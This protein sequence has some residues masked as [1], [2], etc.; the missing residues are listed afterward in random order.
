M[1]VEN[2][3]K[4]PR[5]ACLANAKLEIVLNLNAILTED[6]HD[7]CFRG[8]MLQNLAR[9]WRYSETRVVESKDQPANSTRR[10]F[11]QIM[12]EKNLYWPRPWSYQVSGLT[13]KTCVYIN[14]IFEEI[15]KL[16]KSNSYKYTNTR[17]N[18]SIFL[19]CHLTKIFNCKINHFLG[20]LTKIHFGILDNGKSDIKFELYKMMACF[21]VF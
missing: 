7:V 5:K 2:A 21:L 11:L 19:I 1:A 3:R 17:K 18:V 13:N 6:Y 15:G 16:S 9:L 4:L 12:V 10:S 20:D 14:Y 8:K